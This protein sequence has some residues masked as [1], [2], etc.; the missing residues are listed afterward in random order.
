MRISTHEFLLGSLNDLLAQQRTAD[1]LNREIASG[2]T[3]PDAAAD[4]A[5]AA[6][7]LDIAG[8]IARLDQGTANGDAAQLVAQSGADALKQ[9]STALADLR[10]IA[11][12]GATATTNATQ[13]AALVGEAKSALQ[14]LVDLANTRDANGRYIFA[15][16]RADQPAFRTAADGSVQFAG[17]GALNRY[18]LAPALTVPATLSGQSVFITV[19]AGTGSATVTADAANTGGAYAVVRSVTSASQAF[20]GRLADTQY[21]IDFAAGSGSSLVYTVTSGTGSPGSASFL[22]SSGVVASGSLVEGADLTFGGIDVGI[23]G[24]PAAGDSFVAQTGQTTSI[25]QTAQDLISALEAPQDDAAGRARAQQ[26]IE[27]VLANLDGAD[28][29]ILSAQASLGAVLAEIRSVQ[30]R[31]DTAGTNAKAALSNLQAANLP[32]VISNYSESITVLQAAQLAFV[33]IQ[34]LSLFTVLRGG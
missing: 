28:S 32:E 5:G 15:G 1:R 18:E 14:Q 24:T 12:Q 33:R 27:N 20:A 13:R 9:V 6:Q 26:Q 29:T 3:M 4:P 2:Q 30:R 10:R 19:P 25:F 8:T 16:S 21:Q 17:D 7:A 34:N 31:N 23:V 11:G 22:A